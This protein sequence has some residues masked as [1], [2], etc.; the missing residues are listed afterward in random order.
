MSNR[1]LIESSPFSIDAR[2]AIQLGRESISSSLVAIS[3]LVK[4]AYD[5]DAEKITIKFLNLNSALATITIEDNGN[6]MDS[7]ILKE[8]WLRI[9]TD[10][11]VRTETSED[12][13]RIL[14]GSK[15]LGRLGIDRLCDKLILQ[16]KT[17]NSETGIELEVDWS[18]YDKNFGINLEEIKHNIMKYLLVFKINLESFQSVPDQKVLG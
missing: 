2:V 11:K 4:N 1:K 17:K 8:N 6:G 16:T 9:G 3:E 12:K 13:H 5:A 14:T 10:I 15:G 18:N 7:K